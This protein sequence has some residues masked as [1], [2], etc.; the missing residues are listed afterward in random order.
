MSMLRFPMVQKKN[1]GKPNIDSIVEG[2]VCYYVNLGYG[3]Y[4]E[5][6]VIRELY[7]ELKLESMAIKVITLGSL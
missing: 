2:L 1:V 3:K 7:N 5:Q 4:V 6:F